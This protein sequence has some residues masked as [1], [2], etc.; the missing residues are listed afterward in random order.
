MNKKGRRSDK[1]AWV[2]TALWGKNRAPSWQL[3]WSPLIVKQ[4]GNVIIYFSSHPWI[5]ETNAIINN[6][7]VQVEDKDEEVAMVD[8]FQTAT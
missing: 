7:D 2:Y 6:E 3:I 4:I 5:N 8:L 1:Q